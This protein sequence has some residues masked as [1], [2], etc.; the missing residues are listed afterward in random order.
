M[1]KKEALSGVKWTFLEQFGT[2][3]ISFIVSIV[4]ARLL[5]PEEFGLIAT[6]TVFIGI[7]NALLNGG[8]SSSLIR[9]KEINE[10]DY[11]TVFYFNLVVSVLIYAITYVSAPYIASFYNQTILIPLIR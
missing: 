7:G 8:M 4:L 5:K 3:T 9:S 1:L 10:E 6:I 2:Q 11:S